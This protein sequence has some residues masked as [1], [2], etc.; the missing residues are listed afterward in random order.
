MIAAL[1]RD[2]RQGTRGVSPVSNSLVTTTNVRALLAAFFLSRA[3]SIGEA[4]PM[5]LIQACPNPAERCWSVKPENLS[6]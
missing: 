1:R 2:K 5:S 3:V 4:E 6:F